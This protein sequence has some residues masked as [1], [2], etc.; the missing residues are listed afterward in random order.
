MKK[1]ENKKTFR[2][3]VTETLERGLD[4]VATTAE[5]AT[6]IVERMYNDC[7]IVLGDGDHIDTEIRCE[8]SK[9]L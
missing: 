3:Y 9:A 6:D 5:E 2:V 8:L 4:I 1:E 7:E